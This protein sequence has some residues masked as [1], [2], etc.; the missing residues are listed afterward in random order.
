MNLLVRGMPMKTVVAV[1]IAIIVLA[2]GGLVIANLSHKDKK[3]N[4]ASTSSTKSTSTNMNAPQNTSGNDLS[5]TSS[6]M[7]NNFAFS[8]A[9]I[10]VKQ[11]TTVTWT[12]KDSVAH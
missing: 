7:I 2:G 3:T 6:V 12:N 5:A 4:T 8:P 11:G 10:T 9:H 1:V